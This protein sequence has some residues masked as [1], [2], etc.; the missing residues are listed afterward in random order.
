M[1]EEHHSKSVKHSGSSNIVPWIIIVVVVGAA[2]F[3]G[4]VTYEKGHKTTVASTAGASGYQGR[5]GGGGFGGGDRVFGQVTAISSSSITVKDMRSDSDTTLA[6]TSS[7][8]ITDNGQTVTISSI[9]TGDTVIISEN[10][11]DTSQAS[12]ILVNPSFGGGSGPG[13]QPDSSATAGT[14]D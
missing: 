8:Q 6:I 7:T 11:S 13:Q 1:E 5:F 10:T 9:Q 14:T 2:C 3:Y 4:G 12:K